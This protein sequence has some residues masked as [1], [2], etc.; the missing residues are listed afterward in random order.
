MSPSRRSRAR[1]KHVPAAAVFGS[2]VHA[3][4]ATVDLDTDAE[5]IRAAAGCKERM[6]DPATKD[7]VDAAMTAATAA[8]RYPVLRRAACAG[9][10]GLRRETPVLLKL[11]DGTLAEGVLDLAF[12]EADAG[13]D[14]WTVVDFKTDREFSNAPGNY[15]E[16]VRLYAQAVAAATR[17]PARGIILV[18]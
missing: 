3:I 12:R 14:G 7:E 5:A 4:L 9:K 11:G 13:F 8:L 2:L 6:H 10:G 17:L 16:Q 1:K 15:L 18:V